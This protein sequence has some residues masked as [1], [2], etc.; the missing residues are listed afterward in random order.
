MK[1]TACIKT[2]YS[3]YLNNLYNTKTRVVTVDAELPSTVLNSLNLNDTIIIRDK[4]YRINDFTADITT[5]AAK[6]V[7]ITAPAN[8]NTERSTSFTG[9][10]SPTGGGTVKVPIKVIRRK[11]RRGKVRIK[12]GGEF[13][14]ATSPT[15]P[16]DVT[17]NEDVEFII[18]VNNTGEQVQNTF[19]IET[20]DTGGNLLG[21][22]PITIT[23]PASDSYLLTEGYGF[24]LT[25]NLDKI[26]L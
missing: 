15:L 26:F 21:S 11:K 7:L 9:D 2:Y 23:Q 6:L 10:E 18:P 22:R 16:Y 3:N 8:V 24:L 19:I 4:A 17:T 25:E 12:E 1:P 14:T 20:Y 13:N 5:G